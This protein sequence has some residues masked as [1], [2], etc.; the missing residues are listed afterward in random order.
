MTSPVG[1]S[2]FSTGPLRG[3]AVLENKMRTVQFDGNNRAATF[4]TGVGIETSLGN[5][6]IT[7]SMMNSKSGTRQSTRNNSHGFGG[8]ANF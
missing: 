8:G 7:N 4:G 3:K 2:K 5:L 6:T 1:S